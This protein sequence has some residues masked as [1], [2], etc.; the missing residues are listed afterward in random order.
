MRSRMWAWGFLLI[1]AMIGT[2]A[3]AAKGDKTIRL[4]VSN[5][6]PSGEYSTEESTRVDDPARQEATITDVSLQLEGDSTTSFM[7]AGE[8]EFAEVLGLELALGSYDLDV[9]GRRR[10]DVTLLDVATPPGRIL[11]ETTTTSRPQG[12]LSMQFAMLAV[13]VHNRFDHFQFQLGPQLGI[14][15]YSDLSID[16]QGVTVDDDVPAFG[17]TI[18]ASW[19]FGETRHWNAFVNVRYIKTL[20]RAD[21]PGFAD[22]TFNIDPYIV[23]IG[24]GYTFGGPPAEGD[25][26]QP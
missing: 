23:N 24:V 26:P 9:R 5:M 10:D 25:Q 15:R 18:G 4:A 13:Y 6:R 7:L 3:L 2:P 16:G 17:W 8:W 19:S 14:V 20:A 1:A 22:D 12:S 11:S 21:I